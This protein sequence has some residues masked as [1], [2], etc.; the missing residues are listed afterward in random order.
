MRKLEK[1]LYGQKHTPRAWYD[2]LKTI[3]ISWKFKES[4]S[5]YTTI[6]FKKENQ[7]I[8]AL[9]YVDD[10]AITVNDTKLLQRFI[11][12]LNKGFALKDTG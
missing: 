11:D 8:F 6:L 9:I 4:K 5:S 1:A 2:K 3:L 12:E 7:I 10:I